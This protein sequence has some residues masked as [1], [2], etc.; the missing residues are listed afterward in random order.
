[1]SPNLSASAV[2]ISP[3]TILPFFPLLQEGKRLDR[4]STMLLLRQMITG[5][6][7]LDP[8]FWVLHSAFEKAQHILQLSPSYRDTYDF[9][10]VDSGECDDDT[11]GSK[12]FDR[13][14]F[15]GGQRKVFPLLPATH[16]CC[17]F[18]DAPS[19]HLFEK[20]ELFV[21]DFQMTIPEIDSAPHCRHRL[22][23]VLL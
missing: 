21:V 22:R 17:N 5:A 1:L 3:R 4:D 16:F 20:I 12:L 18:A 23:L 6:A 19:E 15:T 7:P 11:Q 13:Y 8:I 2:R 10:W 14:P 9:T